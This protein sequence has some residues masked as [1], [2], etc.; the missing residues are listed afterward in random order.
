ML[1]DFLAQAVSIIQSHWAY[2]F[3]IAF[4][5][6]HLFRAGQRRDRAVLNSAE[7]EFKAVMDSAETELFWTALSKMFIAI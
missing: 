4:A 2:L 6:V 7:S 5:F 1:R 3:V